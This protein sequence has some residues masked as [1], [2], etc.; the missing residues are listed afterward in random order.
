MRPDTAQLDPASR[1]FTADE[2]LR[3]VQAGVSGE[4]E[5]LELLEGEL[6]V[7]SPQGPR[8]SDLTTRIRDR[9]TRVY[10]SGTRVR[11][12]KPVLVSDRDMLE[13]DVAVVMGE[14]GRY[15]KRHPRADETALIV[16]VAVTSQEHDRRKLR[17][18]ALGRAPEV[19]LLD[20]ASRRL[21]VHRDPQP[22]GHF[23]Q[24]RVLEPANAVD[25]PGTP[26]QLAVR[27]LLPE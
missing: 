10:G 19:W 8:H 7:V 24:V 2:V 6:L 14:P 11:E 4:A 12:E 23:A 13:A 5:P 22:D 3:M 27:E 1:R 18:Y 17:R 15:R 26:E 9:L 20:A 21:E 16:E 25:A